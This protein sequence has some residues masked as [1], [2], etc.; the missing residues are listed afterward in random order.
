M[1]VASDPPGIPL[2]AGLVSQAAPF[3]VPSVE[4][5]QLAISAPATAQLDGTTYTWQG[6]S[7]GG[8]RIHTIL[9]EGQSQYTATYAGPPEEETGPPPPLPGDTT[10]PQTKI[11]RHPAQ[12]TRAKLA[13]FAFSSSEGASRFLC[14][15][16]RGEYKPC[17]SPQT[18]RGLKRGRHAFSVYAVDAAG[19]RDGSSATFAWKVR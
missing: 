17:R 16:D 5:A 10:P 1:H 13:T 18:Y 3:E 19:N 15:L 8:A 12:K 2:T 6:W 7:D 4:G 9:A 14:K 11:K